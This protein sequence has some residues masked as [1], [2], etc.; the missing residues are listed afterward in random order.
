M[1]CPNCK[2]KLTWKAAILKNT[3][4]PSCGAAVSVSA[5]LSAVAALMG[6][7]ISGLFTAGFINLALV[8]LV[9]ALFILL[10]VTPRSLRVT[11]KNESS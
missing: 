2:G 11:P 8:L 6:L 7:A 3:S 9:L 4:C 10:L 5:S 1:N